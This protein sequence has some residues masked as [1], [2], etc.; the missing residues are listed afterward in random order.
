MPAHIEYLGPSIQ[1][2]LALESSNVSVT[3]GKIISNI[4]IDTTDTGLNTVNANGSTYISGD[5]NQTAGTNMTV[6]S[7]LVAYVGS[8]NR[9]ETGEFGSAVFDGEIV[10]IFFDLAYRRG[11][12]INSV[13]YHSSSFTYDMNDNNHTGNVDDSDKG[14]ALPLSESSTLPV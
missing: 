1:Y 13:Q 4:D 14:R 12:N 2:A 9:E 3:S 5:S 11:D 7:Y 6:N 8:A 10:G